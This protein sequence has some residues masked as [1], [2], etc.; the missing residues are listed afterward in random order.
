MS[1]QKADEALKQSY[2][3]RVQ[4]FRQLYIA[5]RKAQ[6]HSSTISTAILLT[7][8]LLDDYG[9]IGN[10]AD[11]FQDQL[12]NDDFQMGI[13]GVFMNALAIEHE[14]LDQ[15]LEQ[16]HLEHS[17]H[18]PT[19]IFAINAARTAMMTYYP[20]PSLTDDQQKPQLWDSQGNLQ[21]IPSH[22][23]TTRKA[24]VDSQLHTFYE[25]N[26]PALLRI[27]RSLPELETAFRDSLVELLTCFMILDH[28][29]I[30]DPRRIALIPHLDTSEEFSNRL[31]K[32][33]GGLNH[34]DSSTDLPRAIERLFDLFRALDAPGKQSALASISKHLSEE[35][36]SKDNYV[37]Y[38]GAVQAYADFLGKAQSHGFDDLDFFATQFEIKTQ[39]NQAVFKR[40]AAE[41]PSEN[42]GSYVGEPVRLVLCA[43]FLINQDDDALLASDLSGDALLS[44]YML[45]G[46]MRYKDALR[47][48]DKADVLLA[49][50]MGL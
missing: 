5:N 2:V 22:F 19:Q 49:Y 39:R 8:D 4:D 35:L 9:H 50:D 32:V 31:Y 24:S 43:A 14:R 48:P 27:I 47:T 17:K 37:D 29:A 25:Q 40:I 28:V 3:K 36:K 10:I 21:H 46:D 23:I 30:D 44:L 6:E 26:D 33:I 34:E 45:K 38:A 42:M 16:A 7:C 12:Q 41:L 20:V 13:F 15:I 11:T 18:Y 1:V